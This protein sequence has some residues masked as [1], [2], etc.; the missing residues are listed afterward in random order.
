MLHLNGYGYASSNQTFKKEMTIQWPYYT[1]LLITGMNCSY[2]TISERI[3]L[4]VSET[5][6]LD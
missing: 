5:S 2:R 4:N 3:I 1:P 6:Q